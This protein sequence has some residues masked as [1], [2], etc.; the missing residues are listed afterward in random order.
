MQLGM[1]VVWLVTNYLYLSYS[2]FIRRG[3]AEQWGEIN[4]QRWAEKRHQAAGTNFVWMEDLHCH[5]CFNTRQAEHQVQQSHLLRTESTYLSGQLPMR[6][7]SYHVPGVGCGT[8]GWLG[9]SGQCCQCSAA[10]G[11][12][13]AGRHLV[14]SRHS[15]FLS[16]L[17]F[18]DAVA[19]WA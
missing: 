7:P 15:R 18:T 14:T 8:E 17:V 10:R 5:H 3:A 19:K 11:Q 2:V 13:A 6:S 4:I 1:T 16:G 9:A 12:A